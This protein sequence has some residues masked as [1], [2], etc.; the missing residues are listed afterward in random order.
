LKI[1]AIKAVKY[2]LERGV[3]INYQ[4]KNGITAL[5][6]AVHWNNNEVA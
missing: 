3:D 4:D 1:R 5:L 2:L 6:A